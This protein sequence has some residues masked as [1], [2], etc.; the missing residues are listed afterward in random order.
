MKPD[1]ELIAEFKSAGNSNLRKRDVAFTELVRRYQEKVYWAARKIVLNHDDADDVAQSV[2]INV[3]E[4]LSDFKE[5]S[6]FFTWIY[7]ITV[8]QAINHL[9]VKKVKRFVSLDDEPTDELIETSLRPDDKLIGEEQTQLITAAIATLPEKQRA[10]FAM[11]YY[12]ELSYD[13]I[14]QILGTS[15]G[16]LKA[17]YFHAVKKIEE[18]LKKHLTD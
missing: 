11:R 18:Y 3:Y 13:E 12:D 2:F 10:V 9:R 6:T 15:V 5:E 4:A 8:N 17:N 7:R 1:S 14:A 16:G